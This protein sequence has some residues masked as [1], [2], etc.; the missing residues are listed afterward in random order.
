MDPARH[1]TLRFCPRCVSCLSYFFPLARFF[2]LHF[3][4]PLLSSTLFLAGISTL[5]P[6]GYSHFLLHHT[7]SSSLLDQATRIARDFDYPAEKVQR[8]VAEYIKQSNEGL[9]KEGT[10]LSQ[11][12]TFV[13]AVPNGTEKV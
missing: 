2:S 1:P 4:L 9:T 13:T 12:P 6:T 10:T 8:G 5:Y 7:M 3:L 11:I